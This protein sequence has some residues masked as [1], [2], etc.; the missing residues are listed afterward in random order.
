MF[1]FYSETCQYGPH[2][3]PFKAA[4]LIQVAYV[5]IPRGIMKIELCYYPLVQTVVIGVRRE[6]WPCW[7]EG[8]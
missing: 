2:L 7:K 1:V 4:Q 6:R 8:A 5:R 3:V